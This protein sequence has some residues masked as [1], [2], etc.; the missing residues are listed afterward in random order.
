MS[1]DDRIDLPA[2]DFRRHRA[3]L[4]PHL[5]ADPGTCSDLPPTELVSEETWAGIMDLPT[6]V[7]L[8]TSSHQGQM[9]DALYALQEGW[10]FSW[11]RPGEAPFMEEAM[12]L[13][14]EEFDALVFNATHGYYRQA[15]GCLRNALEVLTVASALAV[16]GKQELFERW[17]EGQ[18]EVAFGQARA[19]LRDSAAGGQIDAAAN[20]ASI[21]GNDDDAW[22][23]RLYARLCGYAH[24]RAG[25]NNADFWESNGPV[26]VPRAL[27]VVLEELRETLAVSYLLVRLGWPRFRASDAVRD[28]LS[29]PR[30]SWQQFTTVLRSWLPTGI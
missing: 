17:R 4:A 24:S 10:V 20:P 19:W 11:P 12:L 29:D 2:D 18:Q 15:I 8:R 26:H 23:K 13:A 28:L 9:L 16:T 3:L 1:R 25:Y 30:P 22:L 6:D 14:G 21:F 7:A 5:F 27:E